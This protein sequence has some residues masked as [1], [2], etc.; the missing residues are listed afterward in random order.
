MKLIHKALIMFVGFIACLFSLNV[1]QWNI[2]KEN[3]TNAQNTT[4]A[5]VKSSFKGKVDEFRDSMIAA[6]SRV[7]HSFEFKRLFGPLEEGS[8]EMA[9]IDTYLEGAKLDFMFLMNTEGEISAA[10]EYDYYRDVSRSFNETNKELVWDIYQQVRGKG[11]LNFGIVYVGEDPVYVA[12]TRVTDR[13]SGRDAY[14]VAGSYLTTIL[15]HIESTLGLGIN[16]AGG[17]G[18]LATSAGSIMIEASV[19]SLRG[20]PV[21][22]TL[23]IEPFNAIAAPAVAPPSAALHWGAWIALV[24]LGGVA[25]WQLVYRPVFGEISR[26]MEQLNDIQMNREYSRRVDVEGRDEFTQLSTR[27]NS[28]L[29]TL[30]YAYNLVLK[31]SEIT[32]NLISEVEEHRESLD[33]KASSDI[34]RSYIPACP[35][36]RMHMVSRLSRAI[37][38]QQIE[39]AF[40]PQ[41]EIIGQ[42]MS[43]MTVLARWDDDSLGVVPPRQFIALAEDSSLMGLLGD[44]VIQKACMQAKSWQNSNFKPMP[45]ACKLSSSQ[46]NDKHLYAS[47]TTALASSKLEPRYLELEIKEKVVA[48][49]IERSIEIL[50]ALGHIGVKLVI[51]GFT[52]EGSMKHLKRLP[53]NKIKLDPSFVVDVADNKKDA[54]LIEGV[55]KLGHSLGLVVIAEGVEA[56]EQLEVLQ[57][58]NCNIGVEGFHLHLPQYAAQLEAEMP[59]IEVAHLQLVKRR[60]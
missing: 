1:F 46:F 53:V 49:D 8:V 26:I 39:I 18:E 36:D 28:V 50:T 20:S 5:Y 60:A 57:S 59:R 41:Y 56:A 45:V 7:S 3:I 32:S 15:S 21:Y 19:E 51:G 33:A 22:F 44:I 23:K 25:F 30:E 13:Y 4:S 24:L 58:N 55:V 52:G 6:T 31:N 34:D 47:V 16:F 40:Q 43:S 17:S 11:G 9:T 27:V 10:R 12:V 48:E 2:Q 54:S 35:V 42:E 38:Q 37:E 29:S 14:I